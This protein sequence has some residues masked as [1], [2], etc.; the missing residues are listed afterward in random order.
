L[1]DNRSFSGALELERIVAADPS[2]AECAVKN[3]YTYALGREPDMTTAGHM[4]PS[5]LKELADTF[6]GGGF[7]FRDLV[8]RIVS[9]PTFTSRRGDVL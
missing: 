3:L 9:S 4:D 2:Y 8:G 5:V 7:S 6:R 1:P